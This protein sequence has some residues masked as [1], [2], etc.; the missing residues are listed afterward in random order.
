MGG[1]RTTSLC[2]WTRRSLSTTTPDNGPATS[3]SASVTGAG[4]S[5]ATASTRAA[6][7]APESCYENDR[8]TRF[9]TIR[10][11][12]TLTDYDHR[13]L[14]S[15][16]AA[17]TEHVLH[18]FESVQ[19]L[20]PRPRWAIEN[21]RAWTRGEIRMSESRAAGGHAMAAARGLSGAHVRDFPRAR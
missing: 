19:P 5:H 11:G 9:I 18:L 20:D 7:G 4:E 21:I 13:L 16:A 2:S 3:R 6:R 14:A 17:C 8:D 1:L 10:R 12:E 15:W